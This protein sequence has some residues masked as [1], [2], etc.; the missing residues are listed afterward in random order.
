MKKIDIVVIEDNPIDAELVVKALKKSRKDIEIFV[1]HDGA[2]SIDYLFGIGEYK[3]RN[4]MNQPSLILLDLMIPKI[5]GLQVLE[6]IKAN[7]HTE[8]IP[9]IVLSSSSVDADI[10][11]AY[12][13]GVNA[14]ITK[15]IDYT[16]YVKLMSSVIELWLKD[17]SDKS[18]F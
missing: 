15:P 3:D 7:K 5:S 4:T 10:D 12:K 9:V 8:C 14:F 1:L 2:S 11:K 18:E 13:L 17:E 16:S 6:L